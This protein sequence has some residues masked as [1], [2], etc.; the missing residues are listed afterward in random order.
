MGADAWNY[1]SFIRESSR[2]LKTILLAARARADM[3]H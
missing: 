3:L 2:R 1:G